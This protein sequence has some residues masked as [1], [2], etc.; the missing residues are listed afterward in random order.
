MFAVEEPE[1]PLDVLAVR[2]PGDLRGARGGALVDRVEQARAEE[3]PAVV[4]LADVQVA[5]AELER[6]LQ[7]RDRFLELVD[8]GERAVELHALGARL[9]G[10]VDAGEILVGRHHQVRERLVVEQ[11]GVVLRLDVLDQPVLGQQGFDL[12]VG[13]DD[14]EVDDV[15]EQPGL[16]GLE[17]GRRLEVGADAVAQARPT[18]RRR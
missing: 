14:L 15:V 16:L 8:A 13:L 1:Q 3:P 4:V 9:A 7:Q 5:G 2:A 6:L 18:C 10:D 17:L 12:G 11:P